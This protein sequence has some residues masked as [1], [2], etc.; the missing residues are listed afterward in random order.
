MDNALSTQ[1]TSTSEK[2]FIQYNFQTFPPL[3]TRCVPLTT[4]AKDQNTVAVKQGLW[5]IFYLA[6]PNFIQARKLGLLGR[7]EYWGGHN[8][9]FCNEIHWWSGEQLS[10]PDGVT[11]MTNNYRVVGMAQLVQLLSTFTAEQRTLSLQFQSLTSIVIGT[12]HLRHHSH[13]QHHSRPLN[14]Y[15]SWF[16]RG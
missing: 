8:E 3:G 14:Q 13:L 5:D 4:A 10:S 15:L 12:I 9:I 1:T 11:E 6:H 7:S 2:S 16:F